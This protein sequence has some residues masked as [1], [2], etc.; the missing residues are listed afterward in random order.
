MEIIPAEIERYVTSVI[1][2]RGKCQDGTCDTCLLIAALESSQAVK[3]YV[4]QLLAQ[5]MMTGDIGNILGIMAVGFLAA[6]DKC[7]AEQL[8][9][10]MKL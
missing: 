3:N 7:E 2:K 1:D 8:E 9:R 5:F 4:I 10:L 6:T